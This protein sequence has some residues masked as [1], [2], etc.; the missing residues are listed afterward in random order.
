MF[1]QKYFS[2]VI[3]QRI[4]VIFW[5]LWWGIAFVTDVLGVLQHIHLMSGTMFD[6]NYPLIKKAFENYV[7][8]H[9]IPIIAFGI[10]LVWEFL[11]AAFL[12]RASLLS[13][14]Q[15][16]WFKATLIAFVVSLGLWM[17]YFLGDQTLLLFDIESGDAAQACLQ[18]IS[19]VLILMI[20]TGVTKASD[21]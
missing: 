16:A 17:F 19:L 7:P 3:L 5:A 12:I 9:I 11:N 10:L 1:T 8:Y 13:F 4:I 6:G 18:F 15:T 20:E 21:A 2:L 14:N